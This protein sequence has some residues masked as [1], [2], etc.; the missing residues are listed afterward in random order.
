MLFAIDAFSCPLVFVIP[1]AFLFPGTADFTL[2]AIGKLDHLYWLLDNGNGSL[3][4]KIS[5][6]VLDRRT[7]TS[8]KL[9][10]FRFLR[11]ETWL[12][13]NIVSLHWI[14]DTNLQ[15]VEMYRPGW[16]SLSRNN[17][18]TWLCCCVYVQESKYDRLTADH[19]KYRK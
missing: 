17:R 4:L 7:L 2:C 12:V 5:P 14:H 10:P 13:G 15:V 6:C 19:I 18:P 16:C 9:F 11:R 1:F 8:K 3:Q